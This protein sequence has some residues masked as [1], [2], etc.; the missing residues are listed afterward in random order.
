MYKGQDSSDLYNNAAHSVICEGW[1]FT[2]VWKTL[3][4]DQSKL[5]LVSGVY[6]TMVYFSE[7]L[8]SRYICY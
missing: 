4:Y 3:A 8:Y 5:L 7:L 1:H 6:F 2:H